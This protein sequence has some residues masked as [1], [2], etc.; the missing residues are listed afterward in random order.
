MVEELAQNARM[1][2]HIIQNVDIVI[3]IF[4]VH[5]LVFAT[6]KQASAC[7]EKATGVSAVTDVCQATTATQTVDLAVA[8]KLA[9]LQQFVMPLGDAA[10]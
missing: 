8:V 7:A 3:V 5:F 2:I 1:V 9:A 4:G 10:V 6:R